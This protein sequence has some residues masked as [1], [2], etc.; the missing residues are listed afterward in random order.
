MMQKMQPASQTLSTQD[1]SFVPSKERVALGLKVI[2]QQPHIVGN[3][4]DRKKLE[5]AQSWYNISFYTLFGSFPLSLY[6]TSKMAKVG[7]HEARRL[8]VKNLA[9]SFFVTG[10]FA[11]NMINENRVSTEMV[12]KYLSEYDMQSLRGMVQNR[13]LAPPM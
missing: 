2:A 12:K 7:E 8:V 6:L 3:P 13:Y 9:L 11:I 1:P 5:S 4:S 10:F